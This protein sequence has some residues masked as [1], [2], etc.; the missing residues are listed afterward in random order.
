MIALF[1]VLTLYYIQIVL[2]GNFE[3]IKI[4]NSIRSKPYYWQS[5]KVVPSY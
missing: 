5:E 1:D 3:I 4:E 2:F